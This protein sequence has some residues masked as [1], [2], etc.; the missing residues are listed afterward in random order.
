ME[1]AWDVRNVRIEKNRVAVISI[2][3]RPILSA[4]VLNVS[5]PTRI[6]TSAALNTGPMAARGICQSLIKAGAG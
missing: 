5:D 2:G 6:P 3:R 4:T 1:A